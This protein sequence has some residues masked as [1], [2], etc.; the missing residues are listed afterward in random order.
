MPN[1]APEVRDS[2]WRG[3][4]AD[5]RYARAAWAWVSLRSRG[6][7]VD[8]C[9]RVGRCWVSVSSTS[10]G[11]RRGAM[12]WNGCARSYRCGLDMHADACA[13]AAAVACYFFW[14]CCFC[15]G[16][17]IAYRRVD[18]QGHHCPREIQVSTDRPLAR[19]G[20]LAA[21]TWGEACVRARACEIGR[22]IWTR[23]DAD[24]SSSAILRT[25]VST[26]WGSALQLAHLA[27]AIGLVG[28][29]CA[30]ARV[31]GGACRRGLGA[32]SLSAVAE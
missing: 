18:G 29:V 19:A 7:N 26:E 21:G 24:N 32:H 12:H 9:Y 2:A 25:S 3:G 10:P 15:R 14:H 4:I 5:M 6:L 11:V 28:H 27:H 8:R 17:E 22:R 1:V 23:Q 20:W 16:H 13:G 31:G 30:R